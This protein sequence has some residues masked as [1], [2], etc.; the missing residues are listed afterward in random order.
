MI[1]I[2]PDWYYDETKQVGIDYNSPEEIKKYDK[3]VKF[4][5]IDEEINMFVKALNLK[6]DHTVLEFGTGTGE[7]AIGLSGKCKKVIAADVSKGMLEYASRKAADRGVKNIEFVHSG[8]LTYDN[9]IQVDAIVT[10]IALH[11]LPEFWKMIAIKNM[12][13]ILK[14]GGKLCIVDTVISFD[15]NNSIE[16]FNR[17]LETVSKMAGENKRKEFVLN[18]R[19]EYPAFDWVMENMLTKAGFRVDNVQKFEGYFAAYTCTK[20]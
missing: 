20:V 8:F 11:H 14:T 19:D 16:Y 2:F 7:L 4:R 17:Y 9:D 5:K 12:H 3:D 13:G 6:S 15:V 10:Q 1:N 18:I